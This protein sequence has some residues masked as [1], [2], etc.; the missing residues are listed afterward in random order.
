MATLAE[1]LD[2]IRGL[3]LERALGLRPVAPRVAVEL[4]RDALSLV[5]LRVKRGCATDASKTTVIQTLDQHVVPS[6][7]LRSKLTGPGDVDRE[8]P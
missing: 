1:M 4:D 2:R 6:F 8:V 3:D 5:R 7:D